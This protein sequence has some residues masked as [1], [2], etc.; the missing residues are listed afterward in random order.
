M[1]KLGSHSLFCCS[2]VLGWPAWAQHLQG[3]NVAFCPFPGPFVALGDK[4]KE[5]TL[6]MVQPDPYI[7]G[8]ILDRYTEV[9]GVGEVVCVHKGGETAT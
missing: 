6:I 4:A 7:A 9:H 1:W 8:H 5:F 2:V 3:S